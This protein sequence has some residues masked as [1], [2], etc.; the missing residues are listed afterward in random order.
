VTLSAVS[1]ALEARLELHVVEKP[2]G[3]P[4]AKVGDL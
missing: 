2:A 1:G 3:E 4:D